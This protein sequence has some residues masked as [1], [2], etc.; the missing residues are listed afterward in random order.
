[1]YIDYPTFPMPVTGQAIEALRSRLRGEALT[2]QDSGYDAAHII[3]NG[4]E[5]QRPAIIVRAA[6][7]HDVAAAVRFAREHDLPLAVRSGGHSIPGF[8]SITGGLVVDLTAMKELHI[9]PVRRI[10]RAEAGLTWGEYAQAAQEHGLAT[11]SGDVATVGLAGLTLGGGLGWMVRKYGLTI[12]HL[13]SVELVTADG[14]L[15]RA[16]ANEHPDLFWALRGGGGNFGIATAFEF[17]LE[18]AGTLLGG[19]VVY[20][21]EDPVESVRVLR[22]AIDYADTAPDELTVMIMLMPAPPAPFIPAERVGEFTIAVGLLYA[23][24]PVEGERVVAPLRSLATPIADIV[25]PMPYTGI[26]ALGAEAEFK[27][28]HHD[29]R[30]LF[31]RDLDDA[32]LATVLDHARRGTTPYP[33]AQIRILGGAMARVPAE[34]TA[35]AHRDQRFMVSVFGMAADAAG[36][37]EYEPWFQA[38]WRELQPRAEGVYVNFLSHEGAARVRSAYSDA[39]LARLAAVKALYDPDNLFRRNQNIE[40]SPGHASRAERAA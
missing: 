28:G 27:G 10:A 34:A 6:D 23:G 9:D 5:Q 35:F 13:L 30:S 16:S 12:D 26:F 24:D 7:G 31:T 21:A 36:R 22:A 2:P 25:G 14:R 4:A 39:T 32:T 20:S 38:F 17:R 29:V 1:V 8:S 37:A 3:W 19:A 40:P 33:R 11:T 15:L 18:P